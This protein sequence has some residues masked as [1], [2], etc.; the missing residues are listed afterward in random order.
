MLAE[1]FEFD[2]EYLKDWG[3]MILYTDDNGGFNNIESDSQLSFNTVS[4]QNGKKFE[5]T[6]AVYEDCIQLTFQ[7]LLQDK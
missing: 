2:G 5:L 7:I 6:T 4:L 1:D 3:Y